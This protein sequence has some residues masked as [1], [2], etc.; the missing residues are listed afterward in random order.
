MRPTWL[1]AGGGFLLAILWMDL[2]FDVQVLRQAPA[3]T[4]LPEAVLL[5]IA[6]YYRR[7]TTDADPMGRLIGAVMFAT[8]LG[9]IRAALRASDRGLAW[10][11]VALCSGPVALAGLRVFP[12]AVRLGKRM[13][14]VTEQSD[15]A[16]AIC[17]DHAI[18]LVTIAAFTALQLVRARRSRVRPPRTPSRL[19]SSPG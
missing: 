14:S 12:N 15:L 7:V 13:G 6:T 2:M 19:P 10:L 3:P 9:S 11:A 8:V 16:R 1:A 17:R 18:C 5:S 4:E